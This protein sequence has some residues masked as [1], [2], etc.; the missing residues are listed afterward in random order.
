[1]RIFYISPVWILVISFMLWPCFQLLATLVSRI[2]PSA[3]YSKNAFLFKERKWEKE[4]ALYT[5]V[6]KIKKWK[7]YLPDGAAVSKNGYR[8]RHLRDFT[9]ENL[10]IFVEET[11]RSEL[12]HILAILPFWVFGLFA[13]ISIIIFMLIYALIVNVPCII[14]QRYNR[15]RIIRL[16]KKSLGRRSL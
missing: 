1:M 8:K 14:A 15:P 9:T 11:C 3:W 5:K 6:F 4:G 12:A 2:T 7:K 10:D 16:T 13:P